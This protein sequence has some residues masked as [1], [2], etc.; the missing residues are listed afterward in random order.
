MLFAL[1]AA[2]VIAVVL[3]AAALSLFLRRHGESTQAEPAGRRHYLPESDDAG[4][5]SS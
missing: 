3:A 4:R 5:S 1:I 2:L